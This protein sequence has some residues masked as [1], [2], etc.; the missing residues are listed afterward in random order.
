MDFLLAAQRR[1]AR[2]MQFQRWLLLILRCLALLV[3][4]AAV[5]QMVA[6]CTKI[7]GII[8]EDRVIVVLLDD[9][10]SMGY[11]DPAAK[12]KDSH[13]DQAK[14]LVVDWLQT[15]QPGDK[16]AVVRTSRGSQPLMEK[17]T[18]DKN[19]VR[20]LVQ[21]M[22]VSDGGTDLQGAMAKATKI[23]LDAKA[24]GGTA[25]VLLLTDLSYSSIAYGRPKGNQVKDQLQKAAE[26]L[27]K[28][29]VLRVVDV[30]A[31]DQ[32]NKGI[33]T[34][35]TK[36]PV[37]VANSITRLIVGVTNGTKLEQNNL[38]VTLLV[39]GA[40][41][42]RVKIAKIDPGAEG[43][44]EVEVRLKT[45][46]RHV[47]EARIEGDLVAV[48]DV[49]RIVVDAEEHTPVLVI[50]GDPGDKNFGTTYLEVALGRTPGGQPDPD[51]EFFPTAKTELEL[52]TENLDPYDA[53]VLSDIGDMAQKTTDHLRAYVENGGLLVVFPGPRVSPDSMEKSLG[54]NGARLLPAKL[55]QLVKPE[56]GD[57]GGLPFDPMNYE[58]PYLEDFALALKNHE[59]A[60]LVRPRTTQYFK[61]ALP[62]DGS[63]QV[64]MRYKA[65]EQQTGEGDPA[66]VV[67]RV[68]K[69][70]VILFA[71]SAGLGWTSFA[72]FPDFQEFIQSVMFH[73]ISRGSERYTLNVND[74][75]NLPRDVAE[76]GPHWF[77]PHNSTIAVAEET[78]KDHKARLTSGP[79]TQA[80]LYGPEG[81][82]MAMIAVNVD[83]DEADIR[84]LTKGQFGDVLKMEPAEILENPAKIDASTAKAGAE[85]GGKLPRILL[86]AALVLFGLETLF[87][88]LFSVY[89]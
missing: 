47:I 53:V 79:L 33:T 58:H 74:S 18:P 7:G 22:P 62:T 23:V 29:A 5:A 63:A 59:Q 45:K 21:E 48:D 67:R 60:Q 20:R 38:E 82:T 72:T 2:R 56:T 17:P 84:H 40:E 80:G 44:R 70:N 3:L 24:G 51:E 50:D 26:E 85:G 76:P 49:R 64:I 46:G 69:G 28:N 13:L 39:D 1:N 42:G 11:A 41:A 73:A 66:V 71:S 4:G 61:L 86:F 19:E 25:E 55:V 68:G 83:D 34:L 88:R 77:A 89:R 35:R 87:A 16:V 12:S 30:G 36:R 8:G 57:Q 9:S 75:I 81:A 14:K 32:V 6:G 43:S 54:E 27:R 10:Y 37:V 31:D 65:P 15:L 78:D 52:P